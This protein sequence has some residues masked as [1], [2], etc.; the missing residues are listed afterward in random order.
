MIRL[1]IAL[2]ST[3]RVE[4][5]DRPL[6]VDTRKTIALLRLRV[7]I[8]QYTSG[9]KRAM[10]FVQDVHDAL[11]SQSSYGAR[12]QRYREGPGGELQHRRVSSY[13]RDSTA[14]RL[15]RTQARLFDV[16]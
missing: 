16:Q 12:Q 5:D 7:R 6:S 3:P 2:L 8:Q 14:T 9:P 1:S 11:R 13:E 10:H 4:V 15:R